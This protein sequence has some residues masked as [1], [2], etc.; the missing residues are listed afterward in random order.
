MRLQLRQGDGKLLQI[1]L[2]PAVESRAPGIAQPTG[3]EALHSAKMFLLQRG[4]PLGVAGDKGHVGRVELGDPRF[5]FQSR[6][7]A[8]QIG[9]D[10]QAEAVVAAA[11]VV[12][13]VAHSGEASVIGVAD[14][15]Q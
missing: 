1:A 8:G 11:I 5:R 4:Q 6:A 2:H 13:V 7:Q 3:R 14:I 15:Q 12:E 10:V 9:A